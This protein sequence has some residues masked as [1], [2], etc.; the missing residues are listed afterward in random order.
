MRPASKKKKD[1]PMLIKWERTN[2]A[3]S[4][5]AIDIF[6]D[7]E[8]YGCGCQSLVDPQTGECIIQYFCERHRLLPLSVMRQLR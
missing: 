2:G 1:D 3:R 4:Q 8:C 6:G 5:N 7:M